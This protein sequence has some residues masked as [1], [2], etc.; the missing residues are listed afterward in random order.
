MTPLESLQAALA[1]EHAAIHVYGVL[2]GRVSV[3]DAPATAAAVRSAYDTHR[4]RRDQL[5]TLVR[6]LGGE[7]VAPAVAYD[8][9]GP[10]TSTEQIESEARGLESRSAAVYAQAVAST[11]GAP[12]Q[13]AI[14]ALTDAAVRSLGFAGE[15]E[16]YPGLPE[17]N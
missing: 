7:P 11:V 14:D 13:W 12:R 10:A 17:L 6:E 1:G 5:H 4:A 2:G 8:L 16:A 9:T 15:P 3:S